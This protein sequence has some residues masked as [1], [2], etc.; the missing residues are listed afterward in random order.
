M[1][2]KRRDGADSVGPGR[3]RVPVFSL[4]AE[5]SSV[6]APDHVIANPMEKRPNGAHAAR[7]RSTRTPL[8]RSTWLSTR[9]QKASERLGPPPTA[10][11]LSDQK[12]QGAPAHHLRRSPTPPAPNL[13]L[14]HI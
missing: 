2:Q 14:I 13:S 12:T 9:A 7:D 8:R 4:R 11:I 1:E 10:A 6:K 3:T 5:R